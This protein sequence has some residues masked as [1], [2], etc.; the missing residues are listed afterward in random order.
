[1][2]TELIVGSNVCRVGG[3]AK[4]TRGGHA[5]VAQSTYKM[6]RQRI[7]F[8][9]TI[10]SSLFSEGPM[11][12]RN[13]ILGF[14]PGPFVLVPLLF[15][16]VTACDPARSPT[17]TGP[18]A[19]KP[20]EALSP[21]LTAATE[22]GAPLPFLTLA[23]RQRFGLGSAVFQTVFTPATGLGPLF[24]A[25]S[26]AECHEAPV[27]G[28]GGDEVETHAAAF[29]GDGTCDALAAS[30]GPTIQDSV[31][32]ALRAARGIDR[33][34]IPPTAT[35]TGRRTTPDV[36][37]FGLLDAV[38]DWLILAFADPDDRN[39]DGISG[40]PNRTPDGRV[41]RFGRKAQVA[42]LREFNDE[43]FVVEMG[44]TNS[45]FPREEIIGGEPF[46]PGVD[47]TPEPELSQGD[48]DVT[49]DF[50]KLLAPPKLASLDLG[51]I[52]GFFVFYKIGCP[53]CHVPALVTGQN[54]VSALSRKFIYAWTDL[55]L[56]DMGPEL[57]D[58]CLGR[59]TP[60]EFRTEPLMGLRSV[61]AFMHD[62]RAGTIEESILLHG[63]ESARSRDGFK[64]LGAYQRGALLKFLNSL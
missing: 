29:H 10:V 47:P 64:A 12:P 58:I 1:M 13:S 20:D 43:A 6:L 35:A 59:A 31:T 25:S 11:A 39:R 7:V 27:V 61:E 28:G 52:Q 21:D 63:G 50:V 53:A 3:D 15:A 45:A 16:A 44:I 17:V 2:T 9:T 42:T 34:S 19:S 22:I 56:H 37:G 40:R 57:A 51:A 41:G 49:T 46:P 18:P 14:P 55:L 24:N 30:G 48:L 23:Q 26:C 8:A 62:G 36:L 5:T 4:P 54:P 33:E 38:P 32:P 60:S